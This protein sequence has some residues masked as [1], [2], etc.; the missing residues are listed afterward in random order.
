MNT[1]IRI[2][3]IFFALILAGIYYFLLPSRPTEYGNIK[4]V[5][6]KKVVDGDTVRSSE[7]KKIR[8]IGINAPELEKPEKH[9][10]AEMYSQEAYQCLK[11]LVE[12]KKVYVEYDQEQKDQYGR[13]LCYLWTE[14]P[15]KISKENLCKYNVNAYLLHEGYARTY[16]F[17][18][19]VKYSSL[20][21]EIE[22]DA[23]ADKRGI[24]SKEGRGKGEVTRGNRI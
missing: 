5:T 12:G 8:L 1:K 9:Q 15:Q 4:L 3:A 13:E 7:G 22:Q 17:K 18:P 19:N 24:W 2:S 23:K 14:V 20:F 16:T 11:N 10:A 21:H 6:I